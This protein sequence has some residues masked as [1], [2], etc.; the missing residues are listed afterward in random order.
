MHKHA[1]LP[2]SLRRVA[3]A[4][5][6]V[7]PEPVSPALEYDELRL[8]SSGEPLKPR[9]LLQDR[10]VPRPGGKGDVDL[11]SLRPP[12]PRSFAE[13]VPGYRNIPSS[14]TS[15]MNRSGSAS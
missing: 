7:P 3:E 2:V 5:N 9:E 8:R 12:D 1:Y 10:L 14:W 6:G 4:G 13:P 11:G 15:K